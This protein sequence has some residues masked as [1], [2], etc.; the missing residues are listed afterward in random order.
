M[1]KLSILIALFALGLVAYFAYALLTEPQDFPL[2]PAVA[3]KGEIALP[4]APDKWHGQV[5]YKL[6]DRQLADIAARPEMAGLAVAVIEHGKLSFVK[7]YGVAD[8]ATGAPVTP[9]TLFRWASASKTVAGVMAATF[10]SEGAID[11]QKPVADWGTSLRLP[12]DAQSHLTVAQLLS[13]RTGLTKNA[14]DEKLEAGEDPQDIRRELANAPLQCEPGTCH[15]Y[16]NVAFDTI[17]EI[18]TKAGGRS[19]ADTVVSQLF[20]PLGM[21]SATYGMKGLTGS[22]DWARPY[23]NGQLRPLRESY[24]RIPAAAGVS[25]NIVDFARWLEAAMGRR[26]EIV[27]K[28]VLKLAQTPLVETQ[29]LYGGALKQAIGDAGYGLGWRSF[30]YAGHRLIGHSGAVDGYRSTL[31]FDPET[32][33]GVVALW[34]SDWGVPFRIPFAVFDSYDNRTDTNWLDLSDLPPAPQAVEPE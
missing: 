12:D 3:G 14:Y 25:S 33:T 19:Y 23:R 24:W 32:Q 4:D 34:N 1:K 31:I 22:K 6:L 2:N 17:S 27:S 30:T 7:T 11:L 15:T 18:L 5:D 29:G 20:L 9:H 16:Q 28:S 8:R 26:P 21:T 13:Q 10:A